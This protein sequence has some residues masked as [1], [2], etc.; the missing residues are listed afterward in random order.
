[1]DSLKRNAIISP[2]C[3]LPFDLPTYTIKKIKHRWIIYVNNKPHSSW[4][5]PFN[6]VREVVRDLER[7]ERVLDHA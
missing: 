3:D 2:V 7:M 6:Q 5:T 4:D 1:M